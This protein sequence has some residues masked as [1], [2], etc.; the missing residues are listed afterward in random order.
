M[1]GDEDYINEIYLDNDKNLILKQSMNGKYN[2]V[3]VNGAIVYTFKRT[4][5]S[6]ASGVISGKMTV[7]AMGG[8]STKY[9]GHLIGTR[10]N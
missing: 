9:S 10:T 4:G 7:D 6:T 3:K 1:E 5:E 8:M 2:G